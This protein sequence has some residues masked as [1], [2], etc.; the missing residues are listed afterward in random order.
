M[1]DKGIDN[2][3]LP[4]IGALIEGAADTRYSHSGNILDDWVRST[5]E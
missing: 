5:P 3:K 2:I 4:L 1:R